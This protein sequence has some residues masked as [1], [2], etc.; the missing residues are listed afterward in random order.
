MANGYITAADGGLQYQNGTPRYVMIDARLPVQPPEWVDL[1]WF[2]RYRVQMWRQITVAGGGTSTSEKWHG[3]DGMSAA[4]T[5]SGVLAASWQEFDATG[6]NPATP[7]GYSLDMVAFSSATSE[8]RRIGPVN[9]ATLI[10]EA[11]ARDGEI[12]ALCLEMENDTAFTASDPSSVRDYETIGR[13]TATYAPYLKNESY[14]AWLA[15]RIQAQNSNKA[16][17][18]TKQIWSVP[19]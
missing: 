8:P 18:A 1:P 6:Q 11:D 10:Y 2:P 13:N 4:D 15:Q 14:A 17:Y 7:N 3:I 9:E 16:L 5:L 19:V 12:L